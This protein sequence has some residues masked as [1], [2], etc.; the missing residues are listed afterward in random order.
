MSANLVELPLHLKWSGP[1]TYDLDDPRDREAVYRIVLREGTAADIRRCIDVDVLAEMFPRLYLPIG[2]R[3]AWRAWFRRYRSIVFE[4]D[5]RSG[6]TFARVAVHD[7]AGDAVL[8]EMGSDYRLTP[9]VETRVGP[10]LSS[11][12]LGADKVLAL[13]GRA[14]ARDFVDVYHLAAIHGIEAM[15][16][17]AAQKDTGF[18]PYYFAV[19]MDQLDRHGR[20]EFAVDDA[21]MAA[22]RDFF[23]QLRA[24]LIE[25]TLRDR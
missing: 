10:A 21:T 25:R 3:A 15:L 16:G 23:A 17:W 4:P 24:D 11:K 1:T 2:V 13:F 5:P 14:E 18:D 22:L 7:T 9:T 20:E 19:A 12:E 8:V 6:P